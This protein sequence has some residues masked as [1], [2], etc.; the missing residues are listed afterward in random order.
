MCIFIYCTYEFSII[1]IMIMDYDTTLKKLINILRCKTPDTS[2][3]N[4]TTM[5]ITTSN[6]TTTTTNNYCLKQIEELWNTVNLVNSNNNI[7]HK[8]N[9]KN[10]DDHVNNINSNCSSSNDNQ[11][12]QH[13]KSSTKR[14]ATNIN[15]VN[16]KQKLNQPINNQTTSNTS[17]P[18]TKHVKSVKSSNNGTFSNEE[19]LMHS[20]NDVNEEKT[21]TFCLNDN[22]YIHHNI[23]NNAVTP[24]SPTN[25]EHKQDGSMDVTTS[26]NNCDVNTTGAANTTSITTATNYNNTSTVNT[27]KNDIDEK[28][29]LDSM[30]EDGL[31]NTHNNNNGDNQNHKNGLEL[32]YEYD[33]ELDLICDICKY[34]FIL[35]NCFFLV[36][37]SYSLFFVNFKGL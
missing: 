29:G 25:N 24:T 9:I 8:N 20:K 33:L 2:N 12:Q 37:I 7:N 5:T 14:A 23:S 3:T 18:S 31:V 32:K 30:D 10:D 22:S 13:V 19:K 4:G 21:S 34:D 6:S 17:T 26:E 27:I 35:F 1:I 16:K 36:L 28:K 11:Q 15:V